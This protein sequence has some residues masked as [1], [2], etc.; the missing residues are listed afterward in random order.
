MY[1]NK[2]VMK[3][4]NI[5]L[6]IIVLLVSS[7]NKYLNVVPDDVATIDYAFR[8]RTETENYLFACYYQM[9]QMQNLTSNLGF[10]TSGELIYRY[11]LTAGQELSS[12]AN[13]Q[14]LR[15]ILNVQS[16]VL[17]DYQ[18]IYI[19]INRCNTLLA[20]ISKPPDLTEADKARWTAEAKFLK[21]YYYFYLVRKYGPVPL[22]KENIPVNAPTDVVRVPRF[23]I[24][25]I[26]NYVFEELDQA[27]PD[28]PPAITNTGQEY[29]RATQIMALALKA[30][31]MVT[32]ASPLFNGNSDEAA[33]KNEDGTVLFPPSVVSAKW[34]SATIAC[35]AAIDACKNQGISLYKYIPQSTSFINDSIV[36]LL[37][38]QAPVNFPATAL[39]GEDIWPGNTPCLDQGWYC[40]SI[41]TASIGSQ[42]HDDDAVL[43]APIAM[44]ELFYT[45]DGVPINE[46][47]TWNYSERYTLR[48]GD[49]ANKYYIHQGYQTIS[50]H[51]DRE[52][53]FYADLAFDG[54]VWYGYGVTDMNSLQ[55]V[56][57]TSRAR[58]NLTG[59][60]AKKLVPYTT[61]F[62]GSRLSQSSYNPPVMRLSDLYLLY[63]E[64]SNESKGP[65]PVAYAYIDSV[66]AR[67]GLQGVVQS[68]ANFS[69]NPSK[70][71]S[72]SGL[73]SIIHQERRIEL[74]FEGDAGWDLR[75]WKEYLTTF[76][77]PVQ[78]WN[79]LYATNATQYF[80]PVNIFIPVV[81]PQSYFWPLSA[82]VL[83][84]NP[85]LVQNLYW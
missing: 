45:K 56:V 51:F 60:W 55:Y 11:P 1:F 12:N 46:D 84:N 72:Q 63:A 16:P 9:Q 27:I 32:W 41:S 26:F 53:R 49:A 7:C 10:C 43:A 59:Y 17:D 19:A 73:R 52:P 23:P 6:A 25:S 68:W 22:E 34:D 71:L 61:S 58:S 75:R 13:F 2:V 20:N 65:N 24:D 76:S 66:R 85:K 28:L 3:K 38:I 39:I 57:S 78:G 37:S 77:S 36:R 33:L 21:A 83:L 81:G 48:T 42:A 79:Y 64:A 47:K 18:N 35:K 62:S 8:N 80:Q 44:A 14:I 31:A 29:G 82:S 5:L 70:P 54:G 15:G 69:T 4:N 40:P 30:K 50:M 74:C 67:A